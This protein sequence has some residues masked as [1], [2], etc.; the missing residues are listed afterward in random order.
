MV[1]DT[2]SQTEM[3]LSL[4]SDIS[5]VTLGSIKINLQTMIIL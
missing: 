3:V 2:E 4:D 1:P 5:K